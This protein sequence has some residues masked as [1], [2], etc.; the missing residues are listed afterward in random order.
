M[1]DCPVTK[2]WREIVEKYSKSTADAV[3]KKLK[4][5][6]KTPNVDWAYQLKAKRLV[7]APIA[8]LCKAW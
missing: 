5:A 7:I 3:I 4:S 2:E 6:H 1:L 8:G